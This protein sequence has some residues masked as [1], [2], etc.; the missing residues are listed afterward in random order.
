MAACTNYFDTLVC[1]GNGFKI[2]LE[3]ASN[4][5]QVL[6]NV[7]SERP[8]LVCCRFLFKNKPVVRNVF[9]ILCIVGFEGTEIPENRF[10]NFQRHFSYDFFH[11]YVSTVKILCIKLYCVHTQQSKLNCA[12]KTSD[13]AVY[14]TS[15][16][17]TGSVC[18]CV[19][20]RLLNLPWIWVWFSVGHSLYEI[21]N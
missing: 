1:C 16:D 19:M 8:H 15:G 13:D 6:Y 3:Y 2:F 9:S 12:T 5:A 18:V 7:S 20:Q 4:R 21:H 14:C 11:L 17:S 10:L